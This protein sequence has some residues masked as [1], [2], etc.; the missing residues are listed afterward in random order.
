M[1]YLFKIANGSIDCPE[2][3]VSLGFVTQCKTFRKPSWVHVPHSR[4][5]YRQN[6]ILIRAGRSFNELIG[7][8]DLDI[9]S[10]VSRVKNMLA[11]NFFTKR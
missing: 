9:F 3:L 1:A 8:H 11:K 7:E 5:A 6:S 4:S 10:G 2:L